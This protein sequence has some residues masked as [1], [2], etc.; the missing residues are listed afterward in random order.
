MRIYSQNVQ[1]LK[2][3][4]NYTN[5]SIIYRNRNVKPMNRYYGIILLVTIAYHSFKDIFYIVKSN[6]MYCAQMITF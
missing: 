4:S 1:Q 2:V 5:N 6:I 3:S